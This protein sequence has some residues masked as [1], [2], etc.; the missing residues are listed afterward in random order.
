MPPASRLRRCP[1]AP[2]MARRWRG[3]REAGARSQLRAR[4]GRGSG[5]CPHRAAS[6]SAGRSPPGSRRAGTSGHNRH[7]ADRGPSPRHGSRPTRSPGR[8]R[9]QHHPHSPLRGG[10][11]AG[12]GPS[13]AGAQR[14][15]IPR[16][17]GARAERSVSL[18]QRPRRYSLHIAAA[19]GTAAPRRTAH[20]PGPGGGGAACACAARR[21]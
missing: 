1:P 18:W 21:Q 3:E 19:N 15:G 6:P 4:R 20:A 8:R 7:R 12:E 11:R 2:A 16:D 5:L 17:A 9:Q 13:L 14:A 10:S